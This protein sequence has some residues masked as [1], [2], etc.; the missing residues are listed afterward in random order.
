MLGREVVE[1]LAP[2]EVVSF[3]HAALDI[4][5][6]DAV[7]AAVTSTHPDAIV[8]CAA[9]TAVDACE[10]EQD[11]AYLIN[12]LGVRF[13][14]EG[15][16]RVGA[17]MVTLSTDY[18]FDG[19]QPEPYHEW[20]TPNPTSVY[21]QS[22][23]AGEFEVD[24][25][26]AVVRTSWVIGR[27]GANMAKTIM[28][29]AGGDGPL[30]FVDD[31]RGCPTVAADLATMLRMFV[32]ERLPGTWHVTNQGAVSWYEFAGEVLR[33]AGADPARVEP[34][35]TADLTPP[36]P[37]P[38]PANSVLDNR[39]LRLSGRALLPDFRESLPTLI[40]ALR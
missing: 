21:G 5:D 38:R 12:A 11:R 32:V 34:I 17:Y 23:L 39:A 19:T 30:R 22:K 33:A 37:A 36:R 3:D 8:N 18:V 29:L 35:T 15:A 40:H 10:T 4:G 6:R 7:L 20:D 14:M 28:R 1:A 24:L 13:M 25:E 16:R 31:Q 26:C 9:M 27:Y 2:H